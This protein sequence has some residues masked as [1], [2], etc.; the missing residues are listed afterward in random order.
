MYLFKALRAAGQMTAGVGP[1]PGEQDDRLE[2]AAGLQGLWV[3][4]EARPE[5]YRFVTPTP[6]VLLGGD[7][8]ERGHR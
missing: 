5:C 8:T 1:L 3:G 2:G 6:R 7:P 4:T